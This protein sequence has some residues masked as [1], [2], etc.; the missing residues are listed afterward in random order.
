MRAD[1]SGHVG[2]QEAADH[3][4]RKSP[5]WKKLAWARAVEFLVYIG[6][7]EQFT[8]IQLRHY[9]ESHGL[10]P[11]PDRRAYGWITAQMSDKKLIKDTQVRLK[12][13]SHGREVPLWEVLP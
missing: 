9:C 3:A 4:D 11:P 8:A 6:T 5:A 1:L 13:G 2:A 10:P 12:C 7:G